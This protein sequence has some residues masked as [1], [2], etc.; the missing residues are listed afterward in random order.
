MA[1]AGLLLL[2]LVVVAWLWPRSLA[3]PL[4]LISGWVAASLLLRAYKLSRHTK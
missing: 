2:G 3:V 4:S 1:G